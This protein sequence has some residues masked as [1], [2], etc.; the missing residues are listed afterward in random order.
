MLVI[1]Q[2]NEREL[3]RWSDINW[4]AA[5]ANVRCIQGRIFRAVSVQR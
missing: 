3:K 2:T 1:E 4:T 5:E